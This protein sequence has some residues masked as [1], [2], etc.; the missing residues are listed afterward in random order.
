M[1]DEE[2]RFGLTFTETEL[3]CLYRMLLKMDADRLTAP[4]RKLR[5]RVITDGAVEL[6]GGWEQVD[7]PEPNS[8][9]ER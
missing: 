8:V 4:E 7:L 1:N 5:R 6:P 3:Y 2:P 9:L